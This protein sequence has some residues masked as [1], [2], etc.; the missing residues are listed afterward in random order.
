MLDSTYL[1]S[2]QLRD[3]AF[4]LTCRVWIKPKPDPLNS[5]VDDCIV[6]T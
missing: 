5:L 3:I 1:V 4:K 2:I 6:S